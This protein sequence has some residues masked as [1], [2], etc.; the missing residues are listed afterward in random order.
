MRHTQ[1][2]C[3]E[4][5]GIDRTYMLMDFVEMGLEWEINF[6]QALDDEAYYWGRIDIGARIMR[7]IIQDRRIIFGENIY[8]STG[9]DKVALAVKIENEIVCSGKMIFLESDDEDGVNIGVMGSIQ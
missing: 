6:S 5:H 3:I 8:S 9:A 1:D 2:I 7:A 4:L